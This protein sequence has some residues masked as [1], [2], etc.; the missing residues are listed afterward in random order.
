MGIRSSRLRTLENRTVFIP[1]SLFAS[2]PIE[3]VSA[4][5]HTKVVQ[6]V[7]FQQE[8]GPDKI[9]R[10]IIILKEIAAG[11]GL[12]GTPS[13]GLVAVGGRLCQAN[14]VYYISKQANYAE[15]VNRVNLEILRRFQE[16]DIKL[17]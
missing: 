16:E 7:R 10:G 15:T 3:N 1:N 11:P 6:T 5:P 14:F 12:D 9:G 2:Q 13:A 17:I 8:N 4:A